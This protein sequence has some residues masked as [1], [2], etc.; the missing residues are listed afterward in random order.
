M[1]NTVGGASNQ[2][3]HLFF[4]HACPLPDELEWTDLHFVDSTSHTDPVSSKSMMILHLPSPKRKRRMLDDVD[5]QGESPKSCTTNIC[6]MEGAIDIIMKRT[7]DVTSSPELQK[8]HKGTRVHI[9]IIPIDND[10]A[11][12][13]TTWTSRIPTCDVEE[14]AQATYSRPTPKPQRP[15]PTD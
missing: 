11:S 5:I 13:R 9:L 15:L 2:V 1:F 3:L 4:K 7:C 8:I 6:G 14:T 12:K 10:P